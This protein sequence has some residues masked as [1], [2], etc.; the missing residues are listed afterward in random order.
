MKV[1]GAVFIVGSREKV[2][3]VISDIERAAHHL[4]SV[5][6]IEILSPAASGL[7]RL[8]WRETRLYFGKPTSIEKSIIVA[9]EPEFY[10]CRAETKEFLFLTTLKI[11]SVQN[12]TQLTGIHQTRPKG[13]IAGLKVLSMIFFRG[14]IQKAILKDLDDYRKTIESLE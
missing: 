7:D 10:T 1:S 9:K 2:W 12:G 13:V 14:M 6:Q 3:S 5:E 8:I 4:S 11:E